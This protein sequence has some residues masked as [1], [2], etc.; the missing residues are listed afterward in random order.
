[1]NKNREQENLRQGRPVI[2]RY[3][4]YRRSRK[5]ARPSE[6]RIPPR[7]AVPSFFTVMNLFCG[8]LSIVE[9]AQSNWRPACY[10]I[11]LAGLFDLLDGF[12][13]RVTRGTSDFGVQ[14][15]SLCDMVSFG[16]AS[17]FLVYQYGLNQY[18]LQ[19]LIVASLP[20]I[21]GAVRL[22]R[23]NLG[24][25]GEKHG[26]FH[27]LP[28]PAQAIA[29]VALVLA[30]LSHPEWFSKRIWEDPKVLVPVIIGLSVLMVTNIKFDSLPSFN[31]HA[32]KGRLH[33]L[34]MALTALIL[35]LFFQELGLVLSA[36]IYIMYSI[37]RASVTFATA[38][39]NAPPE[40][41]E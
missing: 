15:D 40:S 5:A 27:G 37:I 21:C 28:I 8:F 34:I 12:M 13:A 2:A 11:L 26:Y 19:G 17:S 22:A 3:A 20:A 9:T 35:T 24:A 30:S 4:D 38:V 7:A 31:R 18:E 36:A 29:V 33:V 1:M 23:F 32:M 6:P 14:L 10:Y 25:D 39:W 16:L 41:L